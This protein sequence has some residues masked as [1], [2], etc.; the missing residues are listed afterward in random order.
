MIKNSEGN[1]L[2]WPICPECQT[3]RLVQCSVCANDGDD[4]RLADMEDLVEDV[5]DD[6]VLL[7]CSTCDEPFLPRFHRQCFSCD[8][9]YGDGVERDEP[10][11]DELNS[12]VVF[13]IA[14]VV[15]LLVGLLI[16]FGFVLRD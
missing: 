4:F 3:R 9:D 6:N 13:V 2:A 8:Y 16:F 7:L 11:P 1:W 5:D 10:A 14:A 12:R 15:I